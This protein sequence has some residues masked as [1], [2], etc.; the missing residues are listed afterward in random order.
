MPHY[1]HR[2]TLTFLRSISP[3]D[4][5]AR[6]F[7]LPECFVLS[8]LSVVRTVP[9]IYWKLNATQDDIEEMT[10][11]EKA[12]KDAEILTAARNQTAQRLDDIE[13]L[14]RAQLLVTFDEVN[15]L[16]AKIDEMLVV[17]DNANNA[18]EV[19]SGMRLVSKMTQAT[20][21]QL[22]NAVENKLGT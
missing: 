18:A 21:Q 6:G 3:T 16:R 7:P 12:T 15:R 2:P 1:I 10:P 17:F 19:L 11:A 14:D 4:L 13:A 20:F 22:R 9:P 5:V 8:N